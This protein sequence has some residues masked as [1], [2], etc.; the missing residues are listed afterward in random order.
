MQGVN[1]VGIGL[2]DTLQHHSG[3][4]LNAVRHHEFT[5]VEANCIICSPKE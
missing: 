2:G 4:V 3:G 1:A 5:T